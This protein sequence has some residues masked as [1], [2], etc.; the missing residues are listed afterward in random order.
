M[1]KQNSRVV[2]YVSRLAQMVAFVTKD[3]HSKNTI[4]ESYRGAWWS[5]RLAQEGITSLNVNVLSAVHA[6]FI[7]S[8]G[9]PL[10]Y[11]EYCDAYNLDSNVQLL[12]YAFDL[13]RSSASEKD[14]T[15]FDKILDTSS[16]VFQMA[17]CD[18]EALC[19]ESFYIIE[20]LCP[21][22]YK[23][24]QL[25]LSYMCQ[26]STLCAIPNLN[27]R[28]EEYRLLLLFLMGFERK[29][30]FTLQETRW[31]LE[32]QKRR[33][34][35]TSNAIDSMDFEMETDHDLLNVDERQIMLEKN[36]PPAA[37]K[38]LPFHIFLL[39]NQDD[40][41]KLIGPILANEL[42]IQNVFEWL[43]LLERTSYICMP[44]SRTV[45]V[46]TAISNKVRE[47]VSQQSELNE[48]DIGTINKLLVT[49]KIKINMLKRLA[50][51]LNKL[52]LCMAKVRVLAL[53]R[54]V[55]F[56]WL[57][58][59]KDVTK[60]REAIFDFVHLL[61]NV[62]KKYECEFILDHYSVVVVEKTLYEDGA[63]L[64]Q[65]IFSEHINWNDRDDI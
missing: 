33:Q 1:S 13:L 52:P 42:D 63:A 17:E 47:V 6:D 65:H 27:D 7:S 11:K 50:I 9:S 59:S 10:L 4:F 29:N 20:Q 39:Q 8:I 58:T 28:V 46:T 19:K 61:K 16:S 34:E 21:Y 12:K 35:Q 30:D 38:H 44:I 55:G 26:W 49:I 3:T 45:L 32:R 25:L 37:R 5:R 62:L 43:Q 54:D 53:V 23:A 48:D 14:V 24:L 2:F 36:Y 57:E 31:Y 18:P 64:V 41:E 60:E 40:Y 22:N 15:R 51:E 56:Y